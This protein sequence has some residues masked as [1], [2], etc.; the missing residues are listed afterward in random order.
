MG[1]RTTTIKLAPTTAATC[2][3]WN[4]LGQVGGEGGRKRGGGVIRRESG[5]E[6]GEG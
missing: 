3:G 4:T 2:A 1:E 5:K 6:R